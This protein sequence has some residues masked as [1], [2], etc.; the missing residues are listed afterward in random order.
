[1]PQ[2]FVLDTLAVERSSWI[3]CSSPGFPPE[4]VDYNPTQRSVEERHGMTLRLPSRRPSLTTAQV[5][6]VDNVFG[7]SE[8]RLGMR[9]A[10]GEE[11]VIVLC[12]QVV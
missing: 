4:G 2:R 10:P 8:P 1:M 5:G 6:R 7:L 9:P 11:F 3:V 12:E